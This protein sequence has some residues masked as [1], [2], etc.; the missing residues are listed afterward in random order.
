MQLAGPGVF[1]PPKDRTAALAVLRRGRGK[2]GEPHRHKRLL[3]AARRQRA[4]PRG[5]LTLSPRPRHRHKIGARRGADKSWNPAFSAAELTQAVHDN[6]RNLGLDALEVVNLRLMFDR[7]HPGRRPDRGAAHRPGGAAAQRPRPPHRVEPCDGEADRGRPQD[8]ADR[9]R[10]ELLQYR[11]SEDDALIDRPGCGPGHRLRAVLP[12]RRV[13]AAAVGHVERCRS[14]PRCHAAAGRARLAAA[15]RIS[16]SSPARRRWRTC[17]TIS[18]PPSWRCRPTRWRRSTRSAKAS[19]AASPA[20]R[21]SPARRRGPAS[22]ARR[23][24]GR[25][26]TCPG[27]SS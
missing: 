21:P 27:R 8:R 20:K 22:R 18:P 17:A 3:R 4:D 12:A 5:A 13:L 23:H 15:R 1:G 24:R 25:A 10:A 19:A 2:R 16:C 9:L 26:S 11:E 6:L 14:K 7:H